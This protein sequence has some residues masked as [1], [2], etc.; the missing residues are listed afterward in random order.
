MKFIFIQS[1]IA[2]SLELNKIPILTFTY[3]DVI[4]NQDGHSYSPR[5][6]SLPSNLKLAGNLA[7]SE[8]KIRGFKATIPPPVPKKPAHLTQVTKMNEMRTNITELSVNYRSSPARPTSGANFDVYSIE[9]IP[10]PKESAQLPLKKFS[11]LP[12]PPRPGSVCGCD[13]PLDEACIYSLDEDN[14]YMDLCDIDENKADMLKDRIQGLEAGMKDGPKM[15]VVKE[16][17]EWLPASGEGRTNLKFND[18]LVE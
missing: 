3:R 11:A 15:P 13:R 4:T 18:N 14:V 17:T 2:D 16:R 9:P 5:L 1:L 6:P 10:C 7:K 8:A 12:L